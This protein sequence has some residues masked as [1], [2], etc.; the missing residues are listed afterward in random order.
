MFYISVCSLA[1]NVGLYLDEDIGH[2]ASFLWT[3]FKPLLGFWPEEI[4]ETPLKPE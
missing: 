1:W 3:F 2:D 4:G